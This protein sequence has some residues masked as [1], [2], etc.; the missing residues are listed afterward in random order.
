MPQQAGSRP[1]LVQEL[2]AKS[3]SSIEGARSTDNYGTGRWIGAIADG[4]QED[5]CAAL[6]HPVEDML[7]DS[8]LN[9]GQPSETAVSIH[10][11]F[12]GHPRSLI[13]EL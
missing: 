6:L 8:S 2:G 5:A 1:E 9:P 3:G 4:H 13:E 12:N 11:D 10:A 7:G